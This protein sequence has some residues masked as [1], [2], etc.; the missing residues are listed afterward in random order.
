MNRA[1]P[2]PNDSVA[3]GSRVFQSPF[4]MKAQTVFA[5]ARVPKSGVCF[6]LVLIATKPVKPCDGGVFGALNSLLISKRKAA[7]QNAPGPCH[8]RRAFSAL[9]GLLRAG[10]K[11][12]FCFKPCR[13]RIQNHPRRRL[14]LF[15]SCPLIPAPRSLP[16][17]R[18]AASACPRQMLCG[19]TCASVTRCGCMAG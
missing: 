14:L 5:A 12:L 19:G 7:G 2:R 13:R 3:A 15:A 4:S 11:R 1:L 10:D 6:A 18:S 8:A 16:A 17:P 9:S